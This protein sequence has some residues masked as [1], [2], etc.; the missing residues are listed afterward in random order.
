[1]G[2]WVKLP[3]PREN[4]WGK[5]FWGREILNKK[6]FFFEGKIWGRFFSNTRLWLG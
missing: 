1:L 6:F 2:I 5:A 3:D 4:F